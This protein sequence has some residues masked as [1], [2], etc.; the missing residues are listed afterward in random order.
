MILS[1]SQGEKL[2]DKYMKVI[3]G[4]GCGGKCGNCDCTAS[5]GAQFYGSFDP[6]MTAFQTTLEEEFIG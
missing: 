5:N 1:K 6:E 2:D 3:Y 4:K